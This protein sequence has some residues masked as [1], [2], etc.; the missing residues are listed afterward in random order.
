MIRGEHYAGR[1]RDIVSLH[2]TTSEKAKSSGYDRERR[3][4]AVPACG[5]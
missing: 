5:Y 1:L 4:I 3:Q 2:A